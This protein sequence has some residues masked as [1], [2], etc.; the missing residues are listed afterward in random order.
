MAKYLSHSIA[1]KILFI[2]ILLLLISCSE[3]E[4]KVS[5]SEHQD[6]ESLAA[7][8]CGICHLVPQPE[9]L[10]ADSWERVMPA[11][12]EFMG[13]YDS[14]GHRE[15]LLGENPTIRESLIK[16][17]IYPEAPMLS[18]EE[19]DLLFEYYTKAGKK[20][21]EVVSD[22]TLPKTE[23]FAVREPEQ[24]VK[25]PSTTMAYFQDDRILIGDA[26]TQSLSIFNDKLELTSTGN[27][28]EGAVWLNFYDNAMLLTVMGSFSPTE[29]RKGMLMALPSQPGKQARVL[30]D[31]LHRP[32]HTAAVDIDSDGDDDMIIS[33]FGYRTGSLSLYM[34]QGQGRFQKKILYPKAGAIRSEVLDYDG[35]GDLD[36]VALIG[37]SDEGIY[38]FTNDKG[39]FSQSHLVRFP[40]SYGS[41]YFTFKDLDS[42]GSDEIIYCNGDNA[43][44]SQ[45]LKEYH[46]I[47]I[48]KRN[49]E[50][51]ERVNFLPQHGSYKAIAEDYDGDGD[52]DLAAI[53]F[54]PDFVHGI[55]KGFI[56]YENVEGKYL[57]HTM[58]IT[59]LGR[60]ITMDI[61][62]PDGDGDQD[63]IL[64]SL[65]MEVPTKPELVELWMK[66]VLPFIMLENQTK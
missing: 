10:T 35:D 66:G 12:A 33:E 39:S 16:A 26:N 34:N 30:I 41:S 44:L 31:E 21:D 37:Q 64:G 7:K 51:W 55:E 60:W 47:H 54:F 28:T 65:M 42:D 61:G 32:V 18:R 27:V 40:P 14:T 11:M 43:D 6:A 23:L 48:Y 29:L 53:A 24:R 17:N 36:V 8:K 57:P 49:R 46:G 15:M 9:L 20:R 38:L 58:D 50:K 4:E 3:S 1:P 25:I 62:D 2:S 5:L 22:T 63:L 52:H 59:S 56:Y 13:L 45:E 19:Y